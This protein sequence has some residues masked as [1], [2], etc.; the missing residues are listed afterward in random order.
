MAR[1]VDF[2]AQRPQALPSLRRLPPPLL[3]PEVEAPQL[4]ADV[5]LPNDAAVHEQRAVVDNHGVSVPLAG[6]P[7]AGA[8]H[9]FPAAGDHVPECDDAVTGGGVQ[10]LPVLYDAS[11]SLSCGSCQDR[12]AP[13]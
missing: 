8:G 4:L 3:G 7:G 13:S 1:A 5:A 12:P 2:A 10:K 11:P 6:G 9:R